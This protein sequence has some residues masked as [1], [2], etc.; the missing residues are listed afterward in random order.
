MVTTTQIIQFPVMELEDEA[1]GTKDE[2]IPQELWHMILPC[3]SY[4]KNIME[5][6]GYT[7]RKSIVKLADKKEISKMF[8]FVKSMSGVIED[9][10]AMFGVF[11]KCPN[12]VMLLPGLEVF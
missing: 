10:K 11:D 9:K 5:F 6:S 2:E 1:S 3:G 12:K 8:E 4:L 7:K